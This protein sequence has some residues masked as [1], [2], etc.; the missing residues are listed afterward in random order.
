[1]VANRV[2]YNSEYKSVLNISPSEYKPIRENLWGAFSSGIKW[3]IMNNFVQFFSNIS[4]AYHISKT[5]I[6]G[7][8][9]HGLIS[10]VCG[11]FI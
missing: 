5:P 1:M 8:T 10:P 7:N 3:F 2:S 4:W 11:W 6:L 9:A